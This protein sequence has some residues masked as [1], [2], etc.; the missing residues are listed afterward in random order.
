MPSRRLEDYIKEV[1]AK[2]A[3]SHENEL[4]LAIAE[5]KAALREHTIRLRKMVAEK[6][7]RLWPP[8]RCEVGKCLL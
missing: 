2:V 6:L 3:A 8:V 4:D 1:C 7:A 5:L